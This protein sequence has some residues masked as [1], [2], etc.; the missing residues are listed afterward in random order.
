MCG[1]LVRSNNTV[2][3][4]NK[5]ITMHRVNT[6][7]IKNPTLRNLVLEFSHKKFMLMEPCL[8]FISCLSTEKFV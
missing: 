2:I 1:A 8:R 7:I 5:S 6:K 3:N 4:I